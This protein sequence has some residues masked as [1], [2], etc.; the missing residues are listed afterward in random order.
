MGID[1]DGSQG[2]LTLKRAF[3]PSFINSISL[4]SLA[5]GTGKADFGLKRTR[6]GFSL[7]GFQTNGRV[8]FHME[9]G[10]AGAK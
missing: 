9:S 3:L 8:N 1:V 6:N 5:T 10:Q 7:S 2:Q 4:K